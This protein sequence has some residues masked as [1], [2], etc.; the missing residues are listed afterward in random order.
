VDSVLD[1]DAPDASDALDPDRRAG[2]ETAFDADS[3][4]ADFSSHLLSDDQAPLVQV[5]VVACNPDDRL[6]ATL[7]SVAAQDYPALTTLVV[8]AG[9]SDPEGLAATVRGVLPGA[10][11]SRIESPNVALAMN[12]VLVEDTTAPFHVFC[13]DDVRLAPDAVRLLVEETFR[14]NAGVAGAKL[15]DWSDPR[16]LRQVGMSC[17]RTGAPAPLVDP[18]ELDQ[19]QHDAVRD[20]LYVPGG[21]TLVR[22]DLFA[23]LGGFDPVMEVGGEDLD[24]GWRCHLLGARV[25][26][27][28]GARV[29]HRERLTRRRPAAER[30]Q[31][32]RRH[33]VRTMLTCTSRLRLPVLVPQALLLAVAE[34]LFALVTGQVAE[35]RNVVGAWT[36]NLRRLGQIRARRKAL[37]P[38]RQVPDREIRRLQV[39]GSAR[40]SGYLRGQIITGDTRYQ[41]VS[42]VGRSLLVRLRLPSAQRSV[43][44]WLII[45][46][47]LVVGS[48]HLLTQ[49]LPAFGELVAFPDSPGDAL[50]EARSDGSLAGLG[51]ETAA[52]PLLGALGVLGYLVAGEMALLRTLLVVG[53]LLVGYIG[54]WRMARP[55]GSPLAQLA[56][57]VVYASIPLGYNAVGEGHLSGLVAYALA[58]FLVTALGRCG[59]VAPFRPAS[60]L[61]G[62]LAVGFVVALGALVAPVWLLAAPLVAGAMA[63]GS[64]LAGRSRGAGR[65]LAVAAG[66]SAVGALLLL[67]WSTTWLSGWDT[68]GRPRQSP[69]GEV[70]AEQLL[71]FETGGLGATPLAWA[72]LAAAALG[73]LVGRDWRLAWSIRA[74][75]V[76]LASWGVAFAGLQGWL[77]VALPPL[78]LVLA[79]AAAALAL[80]VAMG[81][82]A[83]RIDLPGTHFGWRQV[84]SLLAGAAL[85]V[86]TLPVLGGA[87]VDGRWGS[88]SRGL[89][90]TLSFVDVARDEEAFRV[91]WVGDPDVLPLSGRRY[92]D[93]V[94]Y[95]V[96]AT[97]APAVRDLFPSDGGGRWAD[98]E[99]ALDDTAA[100]ATNRLGERLAPLGVRYVLLPQ[101]KDPLELGEL[102]PASPL[103]DALGRQF[104]LAEVNIS[105]A[106]RVW[107]NTGWEAGEVAVAD[108]PETTL[109]ATLWLVV[110]LG[111][112]FVV[113]MGAARTRG[114]PE[115]HDPNRAT[116]QEVDR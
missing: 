38:L 13:H 44:A 48:R 84:V 103:V 16:R 67:P 113:L 88:P 17:D 42:G 10:R 100:A 19:E 3:D 40:L 95:Q 63:V 18:G 35:A 116:S 76:A 33:R 29:A 97:G 80:A 58:P 57:V 96:T 26:V 91:L 105:S 41:G 83:F 73:L 24:L 14:S 51:A 39:R 28:P 4:A 27:V 31:L 71:R 32:I 74:W 46:L 12:Q 30:Q 72:V 69:V 47:V 78:E 1:S 25:L 56:A 86:G 54:A 6:L 77:P 20:V 90:R 2:A 15:V 109:P 93:A 106:V 114:V 34:T 52:P 79:P 101:R 115:E 64:L 45:V 59:P 112:W 108:E 98:L 7:R 110:G 61:H 104:D 65:S 5:V 75:C 22:A 92:D 36:W 82:A 99:D 87:V 49:G 111:A 81:M 102:V 11:I 23:A 66:A 37:A 68:F 107:E 50:R 89:D 70:S 9:G 53:L 85:V 8:D 43:G 55:T 60:T 21:C 62:V 94:S